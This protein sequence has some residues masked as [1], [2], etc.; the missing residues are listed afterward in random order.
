M[1]NKV[2]CI[3]KFIKD[4]YKELIYKNSFILKIRKRKRIRDFNIY[5]KL[6]KDRIYS[7][8]LIESL[9]E[10][11]N[12]CHKD[13]IT[14]RELLIKINVYLKY[15]LNIKEGIVLLEE[16]INLLVL[17]FSIE[18]IIYGS[19]AELHID[20]PKDMMNIRIPLLIFQPLIENSIKHGIFPKPI[21]GDIYIKAFDNQDRVE[22]IICDTGVGMSREEFEKVALMKSFGLKNIKD[23]LE[24]LYGFNYHFKIESEIEGGTK[25][26]LTL[27]KE[28]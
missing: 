13:S 3:L 10:A 1:I 23:R 5:F 18:N 4:K 28:V 7:N 19:R 16:E 26:Y 2:N 12:L 22:F 15:I 17:F 6:I 21:G 9:N 14:V 11:S 27:P 20:I 8:F 24:M 25:V